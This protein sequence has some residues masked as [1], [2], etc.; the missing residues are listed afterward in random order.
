V[1][2]RTVICN[3][4]IPPLLCHHHNTPI[5]GAR[6]SNATLRDLLKTIDTRSSSSLSLAGA[7]VVVGAAAVSFTMSAGY[8]P[9]ERESALASTGETVDL[10]PVGFVQLLLGNAD[11]RVPPGADGI[12]TLVT[13][14]KGLGLFQKPF[15]VYS[16]VAETVGLLLAYISRKRPEDWNAAASERLAR[17]ALTAIYKRQLDSE[18]HLS[19]VLGASLF[20]QQALQL[21]TPR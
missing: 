6:F 21:T 16:R 11:A 2:I 1:C 7:R 4:M 19:G 8:A 20:A 9:F 14:L 18:E 10:K 17:A 12:F 15:A 5:A 3:Y 13:S